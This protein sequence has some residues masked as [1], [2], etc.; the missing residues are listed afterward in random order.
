M[1][2]LERDV[3]KENT[4]Q[5]KVNRRTIFRR[6]EKNP[7]VNRRFT[8]LYF[9][10]PSLGHMLLNIGNISINLSHI[11]QNLGHFSKHL[12]KLFWLNQSHLGLNL[13]HIVHIL[14]QIGMQ[15]VIKCLNLRNMGL[16]LSQ[17]WDKGISKNNLPV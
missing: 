11:G 8:F 14:G 15:N 13:G 2:I 7:K 6:K 12:D 17:G 1:T 16:N 5:K 9:F 3:R 10:L 4:L